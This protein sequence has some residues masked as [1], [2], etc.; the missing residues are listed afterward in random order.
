[1]TGAR[2]PPTAP[3]AGP[4]ANSQPSEEFLRR[5]RELGVEVVPP[6]RLRR[7]LVREPTLPRATPADV[8][9][10]ESQLVALVREAHAAGGRARGSSLAHGVAP[11]RDPRARS[12]GLI[13]FPWVLLTRPD[14]GTVLKCTLVPIGPEQRE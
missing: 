9:R 6:G 10:Y 13:D 2:K 1:M 12:S 4:E 11:R 3:P 5:A 14:P 8:A 7:R